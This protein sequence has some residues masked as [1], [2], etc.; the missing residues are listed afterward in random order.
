MHDD[1][2]RR[3]GACERTNTF[4]CP[5]GKAA[6]PQDTRERNLWRSRVCKMARLG[7]AQRR[8]PLHAFVEVDLRFR[9]VAD[10]VVGN[11]DE[12]LGTR[13]PRRVADQ[14]RDPLGL[15]GNRQQ[16]PIFAGPAIEHVQPCQQPEFIGQIAEGFGDLKTATE[17]ALGLR[18]VAFRKHESVA[19]RRLEFQLP[20]TPAAR[21]IEGRQCTTGPETSLVQQVQLDK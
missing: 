14:P 1:V 4:D 7:A 3:R 18:A 5:V 13:D 20:R 19:Q 2:T 9:L 12:S 16:V 8:I 10:K 6:Q 17:R 11:P 21:V 15:E